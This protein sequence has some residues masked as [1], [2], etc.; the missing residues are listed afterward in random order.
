MRNVSAALLD[1][2]QVS[3]HNPEGDFAATYV[4]ER[5]ARYTG[6][7]TVDQIHLITTGRL[8]QMADRTFV[9]VRGTIESVRVFPKYRIDEDRPSAAI[10][11]S[12]G[13]GAETIIA[14]RD[15]E[16]ARIWGYLVMGRVVS[17]SGTVR[18]PPGAPEFIQFDRLLA[19]PAHDVTAEDY[20]FAYGVQEANREAELVGAR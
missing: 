18:R 17:V 2:S 10:R 4:D 9:T 14:V 15:V 11:L 19:D 12:S 3:S 6:R 8:S 16:Y 20:V 13:T 5:Y 1:P 7:V